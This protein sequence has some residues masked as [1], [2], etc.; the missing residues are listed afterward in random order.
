MTFLSRAELPILDDPDRSFEGQWTN[1]QN[2]EFSS[3]W[4]HNWTKKD[5]DLFF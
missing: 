1:P 3:R 2:Q 4:Q 5:T